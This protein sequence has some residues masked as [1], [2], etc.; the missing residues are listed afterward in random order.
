MGLKFLF[1]GINMS[2]STSLMSSGRVVS[3]VQFISQVKTQ[4]CI[5]VQDLNVHSLDV[6]WCMWK[7]SAAVEVHHQL[8]G[9]PIIDLEEVLLVLVNKVLG[10]FSVLT[11]VPISDEAN[12]C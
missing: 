5:S 1:K 10:L 11:A 4:I 12:N 6:C 3:P 9:F 8:L 2:L 7:I